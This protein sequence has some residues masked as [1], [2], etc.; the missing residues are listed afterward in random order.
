MKDFPGVPT[1][2]NVGNSTDFPSATP[3]KPPS[4]WPDD[5]G[6]KGAL[7]DRPSIGNTH[8]HQAHSVGYHDSPHGT[9]YENHGFDAVHIMHGARGKDGE[10]TRGMP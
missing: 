5:H 2:N 7:N 3:G 1:G 10:H 8:P 4:R 9:A 6:H